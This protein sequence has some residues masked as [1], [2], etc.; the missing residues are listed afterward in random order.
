M[1]GQDIYEGLTLSVGVENI[2][3]YPRR[4]TQGASKDITHLWWTGTTFTL[5]LSY[6][7]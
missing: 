1:L 3:N 5:G 4:F 7:I 2:L 6:K